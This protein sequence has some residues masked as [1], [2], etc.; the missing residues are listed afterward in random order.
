MD[1]ERYETNCPRC[2]EPPSHRARTL[3]GYLYKCRHE[4]VFEQS[5]LT[6]PEAKD[7]PRAPFMK[8]TLVP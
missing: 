1:W 4:H 5:P 2:F 3:R 7:D 6:E 8:R